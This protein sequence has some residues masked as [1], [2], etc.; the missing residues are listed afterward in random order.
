MNPNFTISPSKFP[1]DFT[2]SDG[3]EIYVPGKLKGWIDLGPKG[4]MVNGATG[5]HKANCKVQCSLV[6]LIFGPIPIN[7][8][9]IAVA[10]TNFL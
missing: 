9:L 3:V 2:R 7:R 1:G 4:F 5:N 8:I 6:V 10:Y